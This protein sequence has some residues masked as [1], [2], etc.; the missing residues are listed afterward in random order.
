MK[1]ETGTKHVPEGQSGTRAVK[2]TALI[3]LTLGKTAS[4]LENTEAKK[5]KDL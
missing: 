1:V 2:I 5:R 4:Q 3:T